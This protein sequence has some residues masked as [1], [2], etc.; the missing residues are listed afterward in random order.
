MAASRTM[1]AYFFTR[2]VRNRLTILRI[3][4]PAPV[5]DRMQPRRDR[6]VR[7]IRLVRHRAWTHKSLFQN[8]TINDELLSD[9]SLA[10]VTNNM[11]SGCRQL[12]VSVLLQLA[13]CCLN[14][15]PKCSALKVFVSMIHTQG[16]MTPTARGQRRA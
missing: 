8:R 13:K 12:N 14:R 7:C 9:E 11:L 15:F 6:G 3:S 2:D 4:D 10:K 5:G 1:I 16:V